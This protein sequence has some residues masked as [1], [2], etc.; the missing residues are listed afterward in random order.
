MKWRCSD[1]TYCTNVHPGETATEVQSVIEG[2]L[3]AVRRNRQLSRMGSGLWLSREAATELC[4]SDIALQT[5]TRSLQTNG[6]ELFTLNG[7]P[8][9]N[10]HA[11][12]V[13]QQVYQPDWSSDQRLDYTLDL[14]GILAKVMPSGKPEGTISS[15]PLGFIPNWNDSCQQAAM[16]RLGRCISSLDRLRQETG[17]S[18]R[19]CLEMEP[20]CVLERTDQLIP[21]FG[22]HLPRAL[23]ERGLDPG[24][25]RQHL[26]IC[27]DVCHQAVMF[28][29]TYVSLRRIHHAEIPIG[30]IQ[31]SSA[32]ELIDPTDPVGRQE[33]AQ[34]IEARYLHQSCY[35][36]A[37]NQPQRVMDLDE[38][39]QTFPHS[40]P[41]RCHFHV[42]IQSRQLISH[43][44]GT[45]QDQIFRALDF[46]RDHP[47]IHPHLEVETYTWQVLPAAVRPTNESA[48]VAGLSAELEWLEQALL[49]RGLLQEASQ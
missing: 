10:F 6:I 48:L 11:G 44:L 22:E 16:G 41:W 13:K 8:Y 24:L 31:I 33:L 28:E 42:P 38:A 45:T 26:G 7:F 18:I 34:F 15:V 1:L 9:G 32:L 43:R 23:T 5:F 36:D 39:L 30:K 29:D 47:D 25:I 49:T 46:L 17:R 37:D 27:F 2:P 20:G 12:R 40:V 21:L 35:R 4:Q 3:A 19:I 14:A